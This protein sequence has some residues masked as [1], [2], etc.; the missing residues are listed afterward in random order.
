MKN[1]MDVEKK[2]ILGTANQCS[3]SEVKLR[4]LEVN[5][6]GSNSG[7]SS[8]LL[9]R[10]WSVTKLMP[11]CISVHGFICEIRVSLFTDS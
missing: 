8:Y 9:C 2:Y 6:L 11:K 4:A 7:S 10:L 1:H 3:Y 5:Y